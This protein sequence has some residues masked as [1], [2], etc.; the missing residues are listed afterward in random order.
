MI[1]RSLKTQI[2]RDLFKGK[3][4]VLLGARQVGKTTLLRQI[5][6][7]RSER[8]LWLNGD[9]TQD[10]NILSDLNHTNLPAIIGDHQMVVIDEAQR[11]TNA[12][13]TLKIIHDSMPTVQ[14][15][16][17]GSSSFELSDQIQEA[18]TGRKWQYQLHPFS[19]GELVADSALST[20]MRQFNSRLIFGNY[21][22]VVN[23]PGREREILYNLSSDYLYKDVFSM[24][25]LRKPHMLTEL[26]KAIALQVGS[27]VSLR[28][29][30]KLLKIDKSTV[31]RYLQILEDAFIIFRLSSFRRNLRSELKYSKKYFFFD[32]G[33]R[34]AII[35]DF[36]A[37]DT[38]Q[39]TRALWENFFIAEK[40]KRS[41][42]NKDF[43]QFYFW[44][45]QSQKE[46]DLIEIR[47]GDMAA[48]ECKWN[49]NKKTNIS[50][51][52]T[53]AYPEASVHVVNRDNWWSCLG[54]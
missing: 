26:L 29:L 3:A 54:S 47:D 8:T 18:M 30:S 22:D 9:Y 31:D 37:I 7:E 48:F 35:G 13:L 32:N 24:N 34:N 21:P 50:R 5:V 28:E 45:T 44:R 52:F 16:V 41:R 23:N 6:T 51:S 53:R 2:E 17:T 1:E 12:G 25:S 11:L 39:D 36:S 20:Q 46:I 27:Q 19:M 4:I 42:Y 38:R 49:P 33:I 10:R 40:L 15:I 14:L 43:A